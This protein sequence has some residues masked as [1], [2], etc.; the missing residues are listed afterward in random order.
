MHYDLTQGM[1]R[2]KPEFI[3]FASIIDNKD[4]QQAEKL[5]NHS[6]VVMDVLTKARESGNIVFADDKTEL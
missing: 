5:L 4:F 1:H 2:M 3:D 6:L